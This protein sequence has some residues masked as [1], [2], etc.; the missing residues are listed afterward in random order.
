M[1]DA[2]LKGQSLGT[3]GTKLTR[4]PGLCSQDFTAVLF[5]EPGADPA[6]KIGNLFQLE[7]ARR[8]VP[9]VTPMRDAGHC[10]YLRAAVSCRRREVDMKGDRDS[11]K[12]GETSRKTG[13][14]ARVCKGKTKLA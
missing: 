1:C 14:R 3:H 10:V 9:A 12:P 11:P 7:G 6:R 4:G 2:L 5:G 8:G 13:S